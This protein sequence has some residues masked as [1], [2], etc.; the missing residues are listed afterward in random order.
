MKSLR[1]S[2]KFIARVTGQWLV[3]RFCA[4][5][6]AMG[7]F[8]MP[9]ASATP[10]SYST[11]PTVQKIQTTAVLNAVP[12]AASSTV[13]IDQQPLTVRP[14]IPPNIVLMLDDSGSMARD[15][16]PD[17]QYI[18]HCATSTNS[19]SPT[20]DELRDA[21][22]NGTYYNPNVIYQPPPK[23][24]SLTSYLNSPG[25][26]S[27]FKN[28]F[29][30]QTA[31][32]EVDVTEYPWKD[33]DYSGIKIYNDSY[34][35]NTKFEAQAGVGYPAMP[36]CSNDEVLDGGVCYTI[37][38]TYYPAIRI[39]DHGYNYHY[40]CN[41]G[42]EGPFWRG[43]YGYV[44]KKITKTATDD[45]VIQNT[46]RAGDTYDEGTK[47]CITG[48]DATAYLFT[49]A[50]DD[51]AGNY[52]QH[53][54]GKSA[55]D[56][57]VVEA[58]E[59]GADCDFSLDTQQNVANWF[60]YYR[61]RMLMA[62]SG[63]MNAFSNLDPTY[64][65]GFGSINAK[66]SAS[67]PTTPAAY[68][69]DDYI[70]GG[71]STTNPLAVVQPFGDGATGSWKA[72]FWDWIDKESPGGST[73]LRKALA[74]V[75][76]YFKTPQPWE[77]FAGEPGYQSGASNP[78][79]A[80]RQSYTI[81]TTDGFWN[82]SSPDV[83]N[84]DGSDGVSIQDP[85]GQGHKYIAA[86]PYTDS[87]DNTLADVAM[88]FWKNDLQSGIDNEVPTNNADMAFWQ[89]MVTF[90]LGMGFTPND[91]DGN[92][93][94]TATVQSLLAWAQADDS[95]DNG[96]APKPAS[97]T[98]GGWPEP[99]SGSINNIADLVHAG[100]NGHGG[101]YSATDPVS[102]VTGIQKALDRASER[103]GSGSG[104]A[105]N[106][107]QLQS[108]SA[109]YQAIYHTVEWTGE[110]RA[111]PITA[112]GL[113]KTQSWNAAN[114]MPAAAERNIQTWNPTTNTMVAFKNSASD[115]PPT[116]LS[117]A[118]LT[119]LGTDAANQAKM[120]DWLRGSHADE[121]SQGGTLRNRTV[122]LGD[123]VDSQPVYVGKVDPNEFSGRT[124]TGSGDVFATYA[125]DKVT[126]LPR[127]YVA[128]NDGMLH[129]FNAD[130]GAETF[131]FLPAAVITHGVATTAQPDYGKPA[132]PHQFFNDGQLT[133]AD[134]YIN[135]GWHTV[136]V[137]TTGRGAAKAV[138]AL[139]VTDPA[140]VTVLWEHS[141]DDGDTNSDYIGQITGKPIIAQVVDADGKDTWV[142]LIANGYNS[143]KDTA[144]LLQFNLQTGTLHV[145]TAGTATGNGLATPA[146]WLGTPSNGLSSV[147]YAGDLKGNVWKFSL[148]SYGTDSSGK[149]TITGTPDSAGTLVYVAKDDN[150]NLQPITAGMLIGQDPDTS[151][152][153][154]FFGTGRYLSSG[155]I[156]DT[157]VQTW[158]GLDVEASTG[159]P[160]TAVTSTSTR[161]D[162][163]E[164]KVIAQLA[165]STV[166]KDGKTIVTSP[167][168]VVSL[169]PDLD[170]STPAIDGTSGWYMDLLAPTTY[171]PV[172]ERMV[173]PTQF[174][175]T[176]LLG[177]SIVPKSDD[178]CNPSGTSWLNLIDPFTGTNP[179]SGG[180]DVNH[181]GVID[182][183]D[184]VTVTVTN[185]DGTTTTLKVVAS[186]LGTNSMANS[187]SN[188][189]QHGI[190]SLTNGELLDNL[191]GGSGDN[192]KR[193]S[194]RE[195][196]NP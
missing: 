124:F 61:T 69:F 4:C 182:G 52:T 152:L 120:V 192:I 162:L 125:N 160:M 105:A 164:R 121:Q 53:Y 139:D 171:T 15:Y 18:G 117:A 3:T 35:Y 34:I 58:T 90:T 65:I 106:S 128:S 176:M 158:Y 1:S 9:A 135:S 168:R 80:C 14:N 149:S 75:G 184:L 143:T 43:Y 23:A 109:V 39:H 79:L 112:S 73:P 96:A 82:G 170:P 100:V 22:I 17:W 185:A 187:T 138:Y 145:H 188:V 115:T 165:G 11:L 50:T 177:T 110:L 161:S 126:R 181:D 41:A 57:A 154:L 129:G 89:H 63:L 51:G 77:T 5:V 10:Q 137:G 84:Q 49:Y 8:Y 40:E 175:G 85:N 195:M 141:A 27:A 99:S 2:N 60:S 54:V 140:N 103:V 21:T 72:K 114:M 191:I 66:G 93:I 16:M 122:I 31:A 131:A 157:S 55:I 28:G 25:L 76:E 29:T 78:V 95:A 180:F 59:S 113:S 107:T 68:N 194:W 134:A 111:F 132:N 155:D 119:A 97:L 33:G 42:D 102:F 146:V 46:C 92:P 178:L 48:A 91:N 81:L 144:A 130:T 20:I 19:C 62:K 166:T 7:L 174:N 30:D 56:C 147:A 127:L 108:N 88:K 153:W 37:A 196:V 64:R 169:A 163:A 150:D 123:I 186:G 12:A 189:G 47:Q 156:A 173:I 104:V 136:L 190:T 101:F 116:G 148:L 32:N 193:V 45:P 94:D 86:A 70:Y 87:H 44:C 38:T 172:G 151:D 26:G 71:G 83:G 36:G 67:I 74:G 13:A 98:W 118:E 179:K 24:D 142:V 167:T 133:V 6:L 159:S 183:N